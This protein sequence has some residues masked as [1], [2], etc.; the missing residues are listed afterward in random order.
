VGDE[1]LKVDGVS[2]REATTR[3]VNI[4]EELIFGAKD[5]AITLTVQPH[6]SS[7]DQEPYTVLASRHIYIRGRVEVDHTEC[8]KMISSWMVKLESSRMLTTELTREVPPQ[9]RTKTPRSSEK[10]NARFKTTTRHGSRSSV[11]ID[12]RRAPRCAIRS[13]ALGD[14]QQPL[15]RSRWPEPCAATPLDWI[16]VRC[17]FLSQ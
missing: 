11:P 6:S 1:L 4:V 9:K 8:N 5:S 2:L 3:S 14:H 7:H 10:S 13:V 12:A 15:L 16:S 17:T